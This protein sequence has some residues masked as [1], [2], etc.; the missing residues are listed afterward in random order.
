MIASLRV[1]QAADA[2]YPS[3]KQSDGHRLPEYSVYLKQA[4]IL[5]ISAPE[6]NGA[7]RYPLL[8]YKIVNGSMRKEAKEKIFRI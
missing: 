2:F 3:Y 4:N 5:E 8:K 1:K 7:L 6:P